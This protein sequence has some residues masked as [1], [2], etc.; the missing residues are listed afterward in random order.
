MCWCICV[1]IVT[2]LIVFN[3]NTKMKRPLF[4]SLCLMAMLVSCTKS[5]NAIANSAL[6]IADDGAITIKQ[7]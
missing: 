3:S 6:H 4:I 2:L 1:F 5:S 7:Q